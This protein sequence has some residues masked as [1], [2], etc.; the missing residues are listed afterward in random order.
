MWELRNIYL[1]PSPPF[2]LSP[3][4]CS[5]LWT[6][7]YS[8]IFHVCT[9]ICSF[10][11][12]SLC[13]RERVWTPFLFS[14]LSPSSP[15]SPLYLLFCFKARGH[16]MHAE[17]QRLQTCTLQ[18]SARR[19]IPVFSPLQWLSG[20]SSFSTELL[21][22]LGLS[23]LRRTRLLHTDIQRELELHPKH[24]KCLFYLLT[25]CYCKYPCSFTPLCKQSTG[26]QSEKQEDSLFVPESG[27]ILDSDWLQAL[28]DSQ[29]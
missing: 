28:S 8:Y 19:C 6:Y 18:S 15:V 16:F 10:I 9:Y 26:V 5:I 1:L 25:L 2:L 17:E 3:L 24:C 23:A 20:M 14:H 12:H 21:C 29:E 11:V 27:W 4:Q 7:T 13:V 22:V